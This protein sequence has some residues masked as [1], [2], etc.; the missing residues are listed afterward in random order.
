MTDDHVQDLVVDRLRTLVGKVDANSTYDQLEQ[1]LGPASQATES[2]YE[3]QFAK[4]SEDAETLRK[5]PRD[6]K[7]AL[8]LIHI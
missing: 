6:R 3:D 4:N 2:K 1:N 5:Q 7:E 8:S